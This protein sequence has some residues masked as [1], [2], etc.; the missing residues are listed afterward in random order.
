MFRHIYDWHIVDCENNQF[1]SP[2]L[3]ICLLYVWALSWKLDFN[4]NYYFS[5]DKEHFFLDLNIKTIG[6]DVHSSVYGKRD[7]YGFSIVNSPLLSDDVPRLP[8]H[9]IYILMLIRFARC[10]TIVFI[11]IIKI[12]KYL[13]NFWQRVTDIK[14]IWKALQV[15]FRA[16]VHIWWNIAWRICFWR[17]LSP[18]HLRWSS[19]QTKDGQWRSE[20]RL[21]AVRFENSLTTLT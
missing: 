21:V 12:F 9:C 5:S 20:C 13:Q 18:G 11:S 14:N 17:N 8:S 16:F 4:N 7:D 15:I 19:L 6:N 2:H 3:H 10:Y 1:T